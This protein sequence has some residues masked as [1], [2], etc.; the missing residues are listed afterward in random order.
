MGHLPNSEGFSKCW[1]SDFPRP[2]HEGRTIPTVSA[3]AW[4]EEDIELQGPAER[5]TGSLASDRFTAYLQSD[6][7]EDAGPASVD[8]VEAIAWGRSQ[9]SVVIVRVC[10]DFGGAAHFFAG[11]EAPQDWQVGVLMPWPSGG[12]REARR[13]ANRGAEQPTP[14]S[15]PRQV[16]LIALARNAELSEALA[17]KVA[18]RLE[19]EDI[20]VKRTE[21]VAQRPDAVT[22]SLE[23]TSETFWARLVSPVP[24]AIWTLAVSTATPDAAELA[25]RRVIAS[26]VDE[27]SADALGGMTFR[28]R[29]VP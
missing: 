12:L 25:V 17:R 2:L 4:I 15:G 14:P 18:E 7:R 5:P 9:A 28:V 8:V 6:E 13:L 19:T 26:C 3:V 16:Q 29:M 20:T 11:A 27:L 23:Q 10:D 22:R 24:V 21:T 1:A